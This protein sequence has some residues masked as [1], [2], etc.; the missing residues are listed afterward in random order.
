MPVEMGWTAAPLSVSLCVRHP[1]QAGRT[2]SKLAAMHFTMLQCLS[3]R[4][5][6]ASVPF[7]QSCQRYSQ[8]NEQDYRF[9]NEMGVGVP[10]IASSNKAC[11]EVNMS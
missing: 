3:S 9:T 2:C 1:S 10:S 7:T 4:S 6:L 8:D 11:A 5:R